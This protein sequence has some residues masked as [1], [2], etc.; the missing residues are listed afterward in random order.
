VNEQ[1]YL[2]FELY[3]TL[4]GEK[5]AGTIDQFNDPVKD[6]NEMLALL[7]EKAPTAFKKIVTEAAPVP[8]PAPTPASTPS[9]YMDL[10]ERTSDLE[11]AVDME[12]GYKAP[13]REVPEKIDPQVNT[14]EYRPSN[15]SFWVVL[16]L[17]I[18]GAAFV[19]Y[20][21]YKNNEVLSKHD[22]YNDLSNNFEQ[23]KIDG[24]WEKVE[25]AK[26]ARN[27]S[28]VLGGVFLTAGIGVHIWF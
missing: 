9:S 5:D 17:D 25:D 15:N 2:K 3:G 21:I 6:I 12:L 24:A 1:L 7:D 18:A 4:R 22:E 23:A 14:E 28:Y 13:K 19:G 10:I 26:T 27:V 16:A 8:V 11:E 20:G